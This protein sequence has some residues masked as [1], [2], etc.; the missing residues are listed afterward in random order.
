MLLAHM[1][2]ESTARKFESH[3][4]AGSFRRLRGGCGRFSCVC[5]LP[6]PVAPAAGAVLAYLRLAKWGHTV[7]CDVCVVLIQ[8]DAMVRNT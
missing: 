6:V 3:A 2:G 5:A 8:R 4:G 7:W 1:D